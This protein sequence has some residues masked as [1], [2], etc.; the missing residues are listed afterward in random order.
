MAKELNCGDIIQGC[1]AR[2]RGENEEEVMRKAAEHAR[3]SHGVEEMDQT[4]A[5]LVRSRI[6]TVEAR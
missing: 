5:E 2:I 1:D 4:T 6:R 3:E